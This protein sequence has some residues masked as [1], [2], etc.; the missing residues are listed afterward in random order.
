VRWQEWLLAATFGLT[1]ALGVW[2]GLLSGG[3]LVGG[4][5]YPYFMPQK[6]LMAN[7]Y[8]RGTIPLWHDRTGLGYPL[9]AESQAGVLYPSNQLLYRVLSV[10]DAYNDSLLLHY[11]LAFVFAWRFARTQRLS[12]WP[13]MLAAMVYVYGWFPARV[14]LEW[15]IIGGMWLPLTL[16]LTDSLLK[17]P[18]R[19]L[20]V[21]LVACLAVHLLAGHF[22]LAFINQLT[23]VLYAALQ[24][25]LRQRASGHNEDGAIV[26]KGGAAAELRPRRQSFGPGGLAGATPS[27]ELASQELL[28]RRLPFQRLI[29]IPVAIAVSL[30]LA[31]IQLLPT[32]ELKQTSQREG[33]H[34]AFNPEYGH[35]PPL[36][37]T[38]LLASWTY[39]HT[40]EILLDRGMLRDPL[41]IDADTNPVEA[42]LYWGLI[43]L[44]LIVFSMVPHVRRRLPSVEYWTWAVLSLLGIV[45]ATGWLLP[46]TRYLPGFTYFMG[47]AR[48][49]IVTALGGGIVCGLV[50]EYLF[51]R[52]S[53]LGRAMMTMLIAAVTLPDL[54]ASSKYVADA[55]IVET[56]PISRLEES[57]LKEHFASRGSESLRL[58]APGPNV[59][60]LY[61]VS[62]V[63]TYLGLGPSFYFSE[64]FDLRATPESSNDV[65]PTAEQAVRLR[66]LGVTHILTEDEVSNPSPHIELVGSDP[67]ALLNSLWGRGRKPVWLHRFT[68]PPSRVTA[69]PAAALDEW[70]VL[71]SAPQRIEF[72][73]TLSEDADVVLRDLMFPGWHVSVNGEHRNPDENVFR[74]VKVP[75]GEHRVVWEYRPASFR[76]GL[77]VSLLTAAGLV[78]VVAFDRVARLAG[79][80]RREAQPSETSV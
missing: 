33:A 4:D 19:R 27:Q 46:V 8:R 11:W 43:P 3:G 2:R 34:Q 52:R 28:S 21:V 49:T 55:V 22:T 5:T 48:Y 23:L 64:D 69:E 12:L 38:Q 25:G 32:L 59:G 14:S 70:R 39:W 53:W 45:Y 71:A 7:E 73:V 31:A 10:N 41:A 6:Q 18:S 67:D 30:L 58:L 17:A 16:W 66:N 76:N 75:V 29:L 74:T 24:W 63:P 60:N 47:P 40:P 56:P 26:R 79:T 42:H 37:A 9:L 20:F 80:A 62:C 77:W 35:M 57:W 65:F 68:E 15:S 44:A 1:L 50:L 36:Y 51:R 72:E 13:A 54:L 78:V 61:G